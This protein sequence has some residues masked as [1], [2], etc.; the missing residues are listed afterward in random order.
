[1][2][3][4]SLAPTLIYTPDAANRALQDAVRSFFQ[5]FSGLELNS[6]ASPSPTPELNHGNHKLEMVSLHF[7][8][9]PW[10]L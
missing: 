2:S 4:Q 9:S 5:G 6:A 7:I 1:M 3:L 10:Y 8:V